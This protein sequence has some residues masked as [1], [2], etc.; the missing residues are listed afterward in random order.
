MKK[1]ILI[2]VITLMLILSMCGCTKHGICESCGQKEK[3]YTYVDP[4]DGE[5]YHLCQY[6][7]NMAKEYGPSTSQEEE[8][9]EQKVVIKEY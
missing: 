4:Y 3:L 9:P 5:E 2:I 1:T 8:I 7:Y 6:C